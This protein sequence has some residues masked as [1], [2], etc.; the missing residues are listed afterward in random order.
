MKIIKYIINGSWN[1][2]KKNFVFYI[3]E[4]KLLIKSQVNVG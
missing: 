4:G 2:S 1:K 3:Y